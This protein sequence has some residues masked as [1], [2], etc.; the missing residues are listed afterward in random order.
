MTESN[1]TIEAR[2]LVNAL[3]PKYPLEVTWLA[4]QIL[5]K[6]VI[7]DEQDFPMNICAMILD[8][9]IYTSVHI[10]VNLNRPHTS[11]R[12]GVIHELAHLYL[13]HKGNIS[14]IEE[15]EDPVLHTEADD[16]STEML[17]PKHS[18]L[19]LAHRYHEP[20]VLIHKILRGYDVSLEMTCRRIL[21]LEIFNGTFTCFNE[22]DTF[23]SYSTHGF[24]LNTENINYIPK[25]NKG[26]LITRKE[27]IH[28]V[29]VN[30]YIKRFIS[31]NFLIALVEESPKP[32]IEKRPIFILRA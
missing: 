18:I 32:F 27:T 3:K 8:K 16:F 7:L 29:P 25:I 12:F 4:N 31:G 26:C 28:G 13:G 24:E 22:N 21:E 10:C 9:P 15:E 30:C 23:F 2:L 5:D 19:M 6:P 17:T 1:A 14:F 20:M 11:R